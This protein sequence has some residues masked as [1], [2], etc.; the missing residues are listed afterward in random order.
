MTV[1]DQTI[2]KEPLPPPVPPVIPTSEPVKLPAS[3]PEPVKPPEP[4]PVSPLMPVT[5]PITPEPKPEPVKPPVDMPPQWQLHIISVFNQP[6]LE[7][8][9]GDPDCSKH[10]H[11]F[12]FKANHPSPERKKP[13]AISGKQDTDIVIYKINAVD[14][15]IEISATK[16]VF[17]GTTNSADY[18]VSMRINRKKSEGGIIIWLQTLELNRPFIQTSSGYDISVSHPALSACLFV[19][20]WPTDS[21]P[22]KEN[23]RIRFKNSTHELKDIP[24]EI[25]SD[26]GDTRKIS[27]R[28]DKAQKDGII[29]SLRDEIAT[30][31]KSLKN[32]KSDMEYVRCVVKEYQTRATKPG[33]S[34]KDS[35]EKCLMDLAQI[36]LEQKN[37]ELQKKINEFGSESKSKSKT[38]PN[39]KAEISKE[40]GNKFDEPQLDLSKMI[41]ELDINKIPAEE[42]KKKAA[43]K[44]VNAKAPKSRTPKDKEKIDKPDKKIKEYGELKTR[45]SKLMN[46]TKLQ[47]S[48]DLMKQ[49]LTTGSSKFFDLTLKDED[50]GVFKAF[51]KDD[52][53]EI[54]RSEA[55]KKLTSDEPAPDN[56]LMIVEIYSQE[57]DVLLSLIQTDDKATGDLK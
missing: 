28:L 14:L 1:P 13:S 25:T 37:A 3:K 12:Y 54:V 26:G 9:V 48:Y 32:G 47:E 39:L 30:K 18:P 49:S 52:F 6:S 43:E 33:F 36:I 8:P 10:Q 57:N 23:C 53:I 22:W 15:N 38:I 44:E 51:E 42:E 27:L 45:I 50:H 19:Q 35:I 17:S 31:R 5:E 29:E 21:R 2:P 24:F 11:D 46:L 4:T 16:I 7:V 34:G 56:M 55:F 41:N 20:N 40:W